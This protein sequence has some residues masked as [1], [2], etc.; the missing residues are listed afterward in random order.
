MIRA[1]STAGATRVAMAV[2]NAYPSDPR[3]R[4]EATALRRAGYGV[5]VYCLRQSN[6][7]RFDVCDGVTVYRIMKAPRNKEGLGRYLWHTLTFTFLTL[8]HLIANAP[9]RRYALYQV[10]TMPDFL[11]FACLG[12]KLRGKPVILDLHDL[13]V[14]LFAS[15]LT[16]IKR[17]LLWLVALQ[18]WLACRFADHLITTSSGFESRLI[19]RGNRA[20]KITLVLNSADPSLFQY[21]RERRFEPIG[22]ELRLLYHGTIAERFGLHRL[23]EAMPLILSTHSRATLTLHGKADPSYQ[24]RLEALV[25]DLGLQQR[26]RF[27]GWRPAEQLMECFRQ[28][29]IAVVPYLHD[30]FMDLAIS[31]KTFEY[32]AAG[33]PVVATRLRA[34]TSI[35][36]EDSIS[37]AEPDNSLAL[38]DAVLR[39]AADP[40][41]RARQSERALIAQEAL[42]GRV[43][44]R[45]Y[46]NLV[47]GLIA[48]KT[49]LSPRAASV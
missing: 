25:R 33:L 22:E 32:A 48:G 9:A 28:A 10:H 41:R 12:G 21:D 40:E 36:P 4:R 1:D 17:H 26:V 34:M 38:A 13:S 23:I 27:A 46:V 8:R 30:A 45:R 42:G 37:Y 15:K 6:E 2:F 3:V 20:S 24:D 18:E 49:D 11:V 47:S 16:G 5:D 43:M 19:Q 29:D 39:L 44:A 35:F 14:E 31:T 7:A